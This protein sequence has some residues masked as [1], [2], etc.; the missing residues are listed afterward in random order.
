[1]TLENVKPG[2]D[3]MKE[4]RKFGLTMAAA[5]GVIAALAFWRQK[6]YFLYF[7]IIALLFLFPA[8]FIPSYLRPVYHSWMAFSHKLGWLMSRVILITLFYLVLTPVGLIMRVLGKDFLNK[9]FDRDSSQSY[10][11]KKEK[12][13]F[14]KQGYERQF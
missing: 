13:N 14:D 12:N 4:L 1:M 9:E 10:W 5:F 8:V 6:D 2:G 7:L 3:K 11:I